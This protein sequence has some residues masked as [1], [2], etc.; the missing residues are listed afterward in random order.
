MDSPGYEEYVARLE[1]QRISYQAKQKAKQSGKPNRP[2]YRPVIID[3]IPPELKEMKIWACW[4][5]V[6]NSDKDKP[7]KMPMSYQINPITG[8]EE[9]KV[10][11]C[12]NPNTW[13]T[14]EDAVKLKKANRSI[15]GF[16]VALLHTPPTTNE[17]RLIGVDMDKAF[18]PDGSINS[19]YLE[20]IAK[21]NTYFELSP[22]DGVRGFCF[23][24][25]PTYGGKHCGNIEI[26]QNGKWMTITG[27]KL[28]GSPAIIN[29]SQET[30]E[31]FRSQYFKTFNEVDDS[32]LPVSNRIF[33]DEEIINILKTHS[34]TGI[35]E[36]FNQF[37]YRGQK[38][39]DHSS[40]DLSLCN[41]MRY[42]TQDIEQVDRIFRQSA[43]MRDKWDEVHFSNGDTYGE[44]TIKISLNTR[45]K[46]YIETVRAPLPDVIDFET[47]EISLPRYEVNKYGIF[48]VS[49]D[50]DGELQKEPIASN[51]CVIVAKGYNSDQGR[52]TFYK[53]L[54]KA[55][56]TTENIVWKSVT[57]LMSKT[58]VM[59]LMEYDLKFQESNFSKLTGYFSAFIN[60]YEDDLPVEMIVSSSGW[61]NDYTQFVVANR[62]VNKD[63]VSDLIQIDNIAVKLFGHSG[64]AE[65]WANGVDDIAKFDPVRFK[66]YGALGC[67]LIKK[68][69]GEN[70]IFDQCCGTTR[71]K[72]F[73]NRLVA[74]M[75]GH[76]K[77]LQLSS[78]STAIGIDKIAAACN[79]LPVFLDE[80]SENV[81][82]VEELIYRFGNANTRVKSNTSNGLE[83]SENY[84]SGL[85]LTGE[86]SIITESSKGGHHARRIPETHGIPED[87]NGTS[88]FVDIDI[89]TKVLN[90]MNEN[91]GNIIVLF[92]KELLPIIKNIND[93]VTKNFKK[94]P[95]TGRDALKER[96]KG[97]YAVM[98][99]AGEIIERVFKRLGM[100]AADPFKIVSSY[101]EENVMRGVVEPDYI[102]F[103][104]FAYDL[105]VSDKAHF[106][107]TAG[108]GWVENEKIELNEKIGWIDIKDGVTLV[109]F[110][111]MS[112]KAHI[113]K[114]LGNNKDVVNRYETVSSLWPK[115]GIS[116]GSTQIDK[117]TKIP[118]VIKTKQIRTAYDDRQSVIQ[119]P[120]ENFYEYLKLV[121]EPDDSHIDPVENEP[122]G[123]D[124][125][126]HPAEF[127]ALEVSVASPSLSSSGGF[128]QVVSA[129]AKSHENIIVH[130]GSADLYNDL[131][132]DLGDDD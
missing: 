117:K 129:T 16:Q 59:G 128:N 121:D 50:K 99:T 81:A 112:L 126:T 18:L 38:T 41:L 101:F 39:S 2:E 21:F 30:I 53:L 3:N 95:D 70:Y 94:L 19:E 4:K 97:Y 82:F 63:G 100:T 71:L 11:S 24:H 37:F 79:D 1:D 88:Y 36:D 83:I 130:D 27:Q 9:V 120:L 52:K 76:P 125:V 13:M 47:L 102:K 69:D 132:S 107:A 105:Y 124:V 44:G 43:L 6:P 32:D 72:S 127:N 49:A 17:D 109:N 131:M 118:T 91:F 33:T 25:F 5:S 12:N 62:L 116:N 113:I 57:G 14:F 8:L 65:D 29:N 48:S 22:G 46:V 75:I 115:M 67:L 64:T 87:E 34:V 98:L 40:D 35:K 92:I 28:S 15:K 93:L 42:Y 89:K 108:S 96:Q 10:A 119:I 7:D 86:D 77:K 23:G 66:I 73:T 68:S 106:G 123:N 55:S 103:L 60:A 85:F 51:P 104:R 122:E 78:R 26:Y 56:P 58:G 110:R 45:S 31:V 90:A 84:N 80:T 114:S 54:I 111:Q 74:S 61:K 20:W